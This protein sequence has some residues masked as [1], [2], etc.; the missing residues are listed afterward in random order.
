MKQ[1]VG[2]ALSGAAA[3]TVVLAG[4]PPQRLS[5]SLPAIAIAA[6]VAV[7]VHRR[8]GPGR[9]PRVGAGLVSAAAWLL[10]QPIRAGATTWVV[11][12][13]VGAGL[14]FL[15]PLP[16]ELS[17]LAAVAAA[18]LLV[19]LGAAGHRDAALAAGVATVWAAALARHR[20]PHP[21]G[22]QRAARTTAAG[23]ILLTLSITFWVG[24]NSAAVPWFGALTDHGPRDVPRVALTFDDGP[25]VRYTLAVR[26]LLDAYGVK[27]TFFTVGRAL[28]ARPDISRALLDDGQLLANHS[29][30]H[31]YWRWLDPGYAELDRTQRAFSDDLGVCPTFFRP[32]HG[33]HTPLM[34]RV[35]H[36]DRMAM[37]TWDVSADDWSS[38]DGRLVA[39]RVL[40]RVRPGSIVLLHDG[41]DGK[42]TSDRSVLLTALP[43]I[44]DGLRSRGL[45][46]VR[47]DELLRRPAY[48][49]RCPAPRPGGPPATRPAV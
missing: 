1:L 4:L 19:S 35:V 25:D 41:L 44:L 10:T 6:A 31:D 43:I 5:T 33:Q 13:V 32:P 46:P 27:G 9:L 15:L 26:D 34:A 14:G 24:A 2:G 16:S 21:T 40:A 3:G 28:D 17:R 8:L 23:A 7:A 30:V 45:Q 22:K 47:L 18:V 48:G 29:Y 42:L 49:A 11:A 36:H 12:A 37:V 38:H 20:V 39:R